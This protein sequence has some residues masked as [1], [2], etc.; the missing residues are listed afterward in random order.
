MLTITSNAKQPRSSKVREHNTHKIARQTN[1][2]LGLNFASASA[3]LTCAA[4]TYAAARRVGSPVAP[5][6]LA[7]AFPIVTLS[8]SVVL[9]RIVTWS[10][11]YQAHHHPVMLPP[12]QS[13]IPVCP[14]ESYINDL[15]L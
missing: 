6:C 4:A 5:L 12:R 3:N 13:V 7:P 15:N 10:S 14:F 11:L 8:N 2:Y 1:L 9:C